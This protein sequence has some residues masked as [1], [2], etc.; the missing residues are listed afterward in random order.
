MMICTRLK[1]INICI[2]YDPEYIDSSFVNANIRVHW[3]FILPRIAWFVGVLLHYTFDMR[4]VNSNNATRATL[5]DSCYVIELRPQTDIRK[6]LLFPHKAVNTSL[7]DE[8]LPKGNALVT[9]VK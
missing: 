6:V 9:R 8:K 3:K 2:Y 4:F 5:P 1:T 7:N